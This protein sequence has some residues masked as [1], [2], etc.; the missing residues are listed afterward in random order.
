MQDDEYPYCPPPKTILLK[1][2]ILQNPPLWQLPSPSI[3]NHV[4]ENMVIPIPK[5]R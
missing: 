4:L 5:E 3:Y 2:P 1:S